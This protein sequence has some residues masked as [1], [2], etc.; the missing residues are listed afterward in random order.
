I[1]SDG[2]SLCPLGVVG[3]I[4]ISG[5]GVARG[6]LNNELL[7]S[8][9]FVSHRYIPGERMYKTGD[10]GRWLSNGSIEYIGRK[11]S[12]VKIRGYRIEL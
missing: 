7:T 2:G 6:Y 1:L 5:V 4:C 3:E 9:K 12:Q 11:D 8:E 10:L